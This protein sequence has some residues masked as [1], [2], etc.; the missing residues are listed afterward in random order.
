VDEGRSSAAPDSPPPYGFAVRCSPTD[1]PGLWH[2]IT[3]LSG[4]RLG[5]AV[6]S[7]PRSST[8]T[9]LTPGSAQVNP[10]ASAIRTALR[11]GADPAAA[12]AALDAPGS[13]ALCAVI[14]PR[15]STLAYSTLGAAAPVISAP[16]TAHRVLDLAAGTVAT[17]RLS[18]GETLLLCTGDAEEAGSL[19]DE[20]A[21]AHPRTTLDHVMSALSARPV[22]EALA[23]LVY[24]HPPAPLEITV[25]ADPSNLAVLRGELRDWLALAGVDTEDSADALLAIGEAASNAAEHSVVG[26]V[27][28][29]QLNVRA[30]VR[31]EQLSLTVSDNGR[32]KTAR[33]FTG[34]RGHGIKL[35]KALMDT[36]DVT[37]GEHGTT[38]T[39][40]KEMGP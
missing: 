18:P 24:R 25:A 38:V 4:G 10:P 30:A 14:D 2:E 26:T 23:A 13:A 40:L 29:V 7:R 31:G 20:C 16:E 17:G 3:A 15:T 35:I 21:A 36:A 11:T 33:D 1:A 27:G 8:A 22:A 28:D 19:L 9:E 37:T 34:H 5:A 6:G 39:M 32:W 12:L